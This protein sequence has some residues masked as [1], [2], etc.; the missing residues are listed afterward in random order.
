[1][2]PL[3]ANELR[4][5]FNNSF[6]HWWITFN[7]YVAWFYEFKNFNQTRAALTT[8]RR[9]FSSIRTATNSLSVWILPS[10]W[11]SGGA[12]SCSLEG[13]DVHHGWSG[14][15]LDRRLWA[16]SGGITALDERGSR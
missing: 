16:F 4:L 15:L 1:M 14:E 8:R 6:T 5:T 11:R 3:P 13:A 10:A 9:L 12:S 7:P 2:P